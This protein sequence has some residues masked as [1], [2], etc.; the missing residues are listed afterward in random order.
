MKAISITAF[1]I[2]VVA[3]IVSIWTFQQADARAELALQRREKMLVEKYKPEVDRICQD[4][5][6]KERPKDPQT[7]DELL[8]PLVGLWTGLSK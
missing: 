6:L 1:V 5:G 3:L 8:R 7:L 4:F 2:S